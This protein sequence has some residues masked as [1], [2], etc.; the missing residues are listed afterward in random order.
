MPK[1]Y[2]V[3][4][5][6]EPVTQADG[7]RKRLRESRQKNLPQCPSCQAREYITARI[8]NVQNK[9]CVSCLSQGRR[10]VMRS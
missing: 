4:A 5:V 8:G 2:A 10:V 1:L 7:V 9:I 3:P 6:P